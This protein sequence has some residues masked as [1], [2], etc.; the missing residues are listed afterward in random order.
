VPLVLLTF[1]LDV[2]AGQL[3]FVAAVAVSIVIPRFLVNTPHGLARV[4][5][6]YAIGPVAT[7]WFLERDALF[8]AT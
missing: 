2:E 1:H 4:S 6:A 5:I 8:A 3:L 7:L